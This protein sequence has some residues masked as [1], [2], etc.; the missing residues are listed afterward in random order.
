MNGDLGSTQVLAQHC[1]SQSQTVS[2]LDSSGTMPTSKSPQHSPSGYSKHLR[3]GSVHM[4]HHIL[5]TRME[6][7]GFI[8]SQA[9]N[10]AVH[11]ELSLCLSFYLRRSLGV[12][13]VGAT[14][15]FPVQIMEALAPP[16]HRRILWKCPQ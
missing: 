3:T 6:P 14:A 15:G 4:L 8:K 2:Q 1:S 5:T 11:M 10:N 9:Q 16:S 7:W 12:Y 13:T